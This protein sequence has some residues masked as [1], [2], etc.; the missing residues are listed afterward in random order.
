MRDKALAVKYE[1]LILHAILFVSDPDGLLTLGVPK[2]IEKRIVVLTSTVRLDDN[3][4]I[5]LGLDARDLLVL[6]S[7]LKVDDPLSQGDLILVSKVEAPEQNNQN[8][9]R[10]RNE[11]VPSDRL[12]K[13]E[14]LNSRVSYLL[15]VGVRIDVSSGRSHNFL[16]LL[17]VLPDM[18]ILHVSIDHHQAGCAQQGTCK[19]DDVGRDQFQELGVTD[20][21][22]FDEVLVGLLARVTEDLL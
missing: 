13:L 11:Q 9:D 18:I 6:G 21:L 3:I 14:R 5:L 19:H 12:P 4:Q 1:A 15:S 16:D 22:F 17:C 10:D 20:L 2:F 8:N 7:D